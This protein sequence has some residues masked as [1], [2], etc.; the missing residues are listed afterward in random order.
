MKF[1]QKVREI[2][3]IISFLFFPVTLYYFS[4]YL[5]VEGTVKG[6]ITGSFIVF[7]LQFISS[8]FLGRAFCGWVC[9]GAGVQEILIKY[10]N[11]KVTKGN[12]IKWII[13]L[14]WVTTIVFLA[15]K[16]GG[17]NKIDPFYQTTHGISVANVQSLF[18]Y[19]A[20][21][22]LIVVPAFLVGKRAFCHTICW[23]APFMILGR[24]IRNF[25]NL[26]S[27][28]LKSQPETCTHCHTCSTKCPMSLPVEEMVQVNKMENSECVLCG[29]CVDG[30][31]SNAIRF[32]FKNQN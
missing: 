1:R 6:I 31:K 13:W 12:F 4:P 15:V 14:P 10:K 8:L 19:F 3:I 18:T 22:T 26:P 32:K 21:L 7:S 30:C 20:I 5:I 29:T 2:L 27:L 11:R 25:L 17:Y 23:M 16:Y 9:P 28:Q 24:K